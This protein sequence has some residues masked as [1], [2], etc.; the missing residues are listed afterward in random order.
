MAGDA[1]ASETPPGCI[2]AI[3]TSLAAAAA[4]VLRAG[5]T[6]PISGE[7][8]PMERGHAEALIPLIDRV[9]SGLPGGFLALTRIAVTV[10]PGS[11]T[12]IRVGVAAARALALACRIP[13]VGVSTLS[14]LAAPSIGSGRGTTI[15]A[16][17]D[18]HHGNVY[19][20]AFGP[21]G[22]TR[23]P[24]AVMPVAEAMAALGPGPVRLIGSGAPLLAIAAWAAGV[25]AEV[26]QRTVTPSIAFVAR[27]G[28]LADP[29]RALP[30]PLYLRA[31][32][33]KPQTNGIVPR[34]P[35]SSVQDRVG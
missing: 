28:L 25:T 4:C 22:T 27:L 30:R 23:V 35:A 5:E 33:A 2:L 10:G 24:P 26:D 32:D 19:I 12:G 7:T 3:D 8:L 15:A 13:A 29:A 16:A 9:I 1:D 6:K 31:P 21:D 18:A 11:F 17:I 34:A 20:Q 14:A